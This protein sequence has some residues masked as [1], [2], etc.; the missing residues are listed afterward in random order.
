VAFISI[1][2]F[3]VTLLGL[4]IENTSVHHFRFHPSLS[5]LFWDVV[6]IQSINQGANI[7][8]YVTA[9]NIPDFKSISEIFLS[10]LTL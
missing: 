1:L 4:R 8:V 3:F 2:I 7:T 10:S 5:V 9:H 6:F